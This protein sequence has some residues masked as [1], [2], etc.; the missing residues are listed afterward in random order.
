MRRLPLLLLLIFSCSLAATNVKGQVPRTITYQGALT[1]DDGQPLPD[2]V[3]QMTF[4]I[5]NAETGST[6]LWTEPQEASV[7]NGVFTVYLGSNIP[8]DLSFVGQRW[9]GVTLAGE[10]EMVPRLPFTTT[11]YAFIADTALVANSA[12][13]SERALTAT[14]ATNADHANVADT[15]RFINGDFVTSVNGANGDI[16]V[17]GAGATQVTTSGNEI[18]ISSVDGSGLRLVTSSNGTLNVQMGSDSADVSLTPSGVQ[19]GTYGSESAIPVITVDEYGRVT[20]V[21]ADTVSALAPGVLYAP[22]QPQ[23]TATDSDRFLFDVGYGSTS[24]STV[25]ARII[26]AAGSGG[27]DATALTLVAIGSDSGRSRALVASGEIETDS[28]YIIR[29]LNALRFQNDGDTLSIA[30]GPNTL[31]REFF[32]KTRPQSSNIA[33]GYGALDSVSGGGNIGIGNNVGKNVI[34]LFSQGGSIIVGHNAGRSIGPELM[35]E[36]VII[37]DHAA[38]SLRGDV[39]NDVI[40]GTRAGMGQEAGF[41]NVMVGHQSGMSSD[42]SSVTAVGEQAGQ[43][44]RS[45]SS[46]YIGSR[47][48]RLRVDGNSVIIGTSAGATAFNDTLRSHSVVFIGDHAGARGH[49]NG[50]HLVAIGWEAQIGAE[51]LQNSV[52]LGARSVVK[53]SNAISLGAR[54]T[55]LGGMMVG[56]AT[57]SPTRFLD[58]HG[59]ARIGRLGTT[60]TNIVKGDVTHDIPNIAAGSVYTMSLTLTGARPSAA[61]TVSPANAL[62]D[63]LIIQYARVSADD[64]IEVKLFNASNAAVN[65][66]SM[67]FH[68]LAVE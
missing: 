60:I 31:R 38:D 45:S 3:Y 47:A 17:K 24:G 28:S 54:E 5:Y 37:G 18:T 23:V 29:G 9:I 33:I 55:G 36:S 61:V 21:S 14:T 27:D 32:S 40:I 48:G 35:S 16:T 15:A 62:P 57:H 39:S 41:G 42:L 53:V 49:T 52:A 44:T 68:I 50:S 59:D 58:V 13:T 46:V 66:A 63:G 1:A 67:Q 26:S 10:V 4:R 34:Q 64:T 7:I 43:G 20:E 65:P 2:G 19:P 51:N 22:S 11:P 12:T 30:I 6:A 56:I 8:L 25:G